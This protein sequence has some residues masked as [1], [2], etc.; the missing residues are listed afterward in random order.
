MKNVVVCC[1]GTDNQLSGDLTTVVRIFE[2]V[3]KDQQQVA[4]Y[5][6]GVGTTADPLA[7][8]PI[9]KRWSLLKGLAFAY[10]R[11]TTRGN[12]ASPALCV[13]QLPR[14]PHLAPEPGPRRAAWR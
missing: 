14:H 4:Y 13:A 11:F 5:D 9:S 8:G 7:T 3:V 6:P 12:G 2:V 10:H 1:D